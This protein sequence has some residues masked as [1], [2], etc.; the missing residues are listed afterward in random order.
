MKLSRSRF[1]SLILVVCAIV[2][3]NNA[4]A[5]TMAVPEGQQIFPLYNQI[6]SPIISSDPT[7]AMPVGVGSVAV[8]GDTVSIQVGLGQFSGPVDIY[9][10][11]YSPLIDPDNVFILTPL[12]HSTRFL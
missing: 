1:F 7:Q 5:L 12:E 11:L 2:I 10:G 3:T 9:F 4:F 8:G 6:A